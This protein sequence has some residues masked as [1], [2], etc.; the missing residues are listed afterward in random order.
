MTPPTTGTGGDS[1]SW[2][3]S[4]G[5]PP[6]LR[7]AMSAIPKSKSQRSGEDRVRTKRIAEAAAA[8]DGTRVLVMRLWPRGV[9][10]AAADHW[11]KGLGTP[12]DLIRQWKAG[13][14]S[15]DT[16]EKAYLGHLRTAEAR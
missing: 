12:L 3:R 4:K 13:T 9:K 11:L 2:R 14:I 5:R 7:V 6:F 10:K 15:W 1:I 16:L 8:D